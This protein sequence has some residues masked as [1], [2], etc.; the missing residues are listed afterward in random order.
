MSVRSWFYNTIYVPFKNDRF[1]EGLSNADRYRAVQTPTGY[2]RIYEQLAPLLDEVAKL[3]TQQKIEV[4]TRK[5]MLLRLSKM[6]I[7][8]EYQ[9]NRGVLYPDLADGVKAALREVRQ[10]LNNNNIQDAAK[11]AEAL[12]MALDAVLAYKFA[13]KKGREEEEE[14]WL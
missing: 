8:L 9:K 3:K 10:A 5:G 7:I 4:E 6:D 12:K 11:Y 13:G 14:E 2:R 1:E